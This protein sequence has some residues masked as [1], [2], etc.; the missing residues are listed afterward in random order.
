MGGIVEQLHGDRLAVLEPG[1]HLLLAVQV[2]V[3]LNGYAGNNAY[4]SAA[5]QSLA[6]SRL[7]GQLPS[8]YAWR[9]GDPSGCTVA[10]K[11][12]SGS[13]VTLTCPA[14]GS[15]VYAWTDSLKANLIATLLGKSKDDALAAC[16]TTPGIQ[17]NTCVITLRDN[18]TILPDA[19]KDVT[20]QVK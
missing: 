6:K 10:V 4:N 8:G 15:A 3:H 16:N 14:T 11:S 17:P 5:T 12:A 20:I 19:A 2:L 18:G 13:K 9:S 7:N 1:E